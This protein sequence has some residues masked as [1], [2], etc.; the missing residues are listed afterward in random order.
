MPYQW[1]ENVDRSK[2]RTMR[3]NFQ[4]ATSKTHWIGRPQPEG[5][6]SANDLETMNFVGIYLQTPDTWETGDPQCPYC[7]GTGEITLL[8]SVVP[9]ECVKPSTDVF[10]D[11]PCENWE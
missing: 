1:I 4:H 8:T 10:P 9:C 2:A 6:F 7:K 3:E 5:P 11:D